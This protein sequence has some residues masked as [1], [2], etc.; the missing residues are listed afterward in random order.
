M[1]NHVGAEFPIVSDPGGEVAN[2]YGVFDL[3]GDGVATPSIF[4]VGKDGRIVWQYVGQDNA[5]RPTVDTLLFRIRG[6]I[7]GS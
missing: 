6:A 3:L 1:S 5:D 7:S 2:E 4:I